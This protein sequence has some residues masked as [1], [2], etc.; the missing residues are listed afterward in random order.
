MTLRTHEPYKPPSTEGGTPL[1]VRDGLIQRAERLLEKEAAT[2][3]ADESIKSLSALDDLCTSIAVAE[4][5]EE[6][7]TVHF[8]PAERAFYAFAA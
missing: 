4:G 1:N 7:H 5:I 8:I 2:L 6:T 3:T